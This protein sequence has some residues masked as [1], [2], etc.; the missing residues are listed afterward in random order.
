MYNRYVIKNKRNSAVQAA[1]AVAATRS[2]IA[3]CCQ[4]TGRESIR[5]SIDRLNRACDILEQR[6]AQ[7]CRR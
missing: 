4:R 2:R 6:L 7:Y 1:A 3:D 5:D